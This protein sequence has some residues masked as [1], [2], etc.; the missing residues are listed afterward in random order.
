M[1]GFFSGAASCFFKGVPEP[2]E[3]SPFGAGRDCKSPKESSMPRLSDS[4]K[5]QSISPSR[6]RS[7]HPLRRCGGF[8]RSPRHGEIPGD[9]DI[10]HSSALLFLE[11]LK[12]F[13]AR[14]AT[15]RSYQQKQACLAASLLHQEC[16]AIQA[17]RSLQ[18]SKPCPMPQ[19][20]L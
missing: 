19:W 10:L 1:K 8:L 16:R 17:F 12:V 11:P 7:C 5:P 15:W 4:D 3:Y 14:N 9:T 20:R 6:G 13:T 18:R 2:T